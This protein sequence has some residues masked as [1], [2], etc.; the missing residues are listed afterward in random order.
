MHAGGDA[1]AG[2][3]AGVAGRAPPRHAFAGQLGQFAGRACSNRLG[4][5]LAS[6]AS[7]ECIYQSAVPKTDQRHR[8]DSARKEKIESEAHQFC[9]EKET[10]E[11]YRL[12]N[13]EREADPIPSTARA[14]GFSRASRTKHRTQPQPH[15]A[16][17]AYETH[18]ASRRL[19]SRKL[20]IGAL[21]G[22]ARMF[23]KGSKREASEARGYKAREA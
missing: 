20:E 2:I 5:L 6:P 16:S 4:I 12:G 14:R 11:S 21:A 7:F 15:L 1:P 9:S 10:E 13:R 19:G 23:H 18:S 22:L 17:F 3:K 8:P